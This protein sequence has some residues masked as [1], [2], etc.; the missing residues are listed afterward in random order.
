MGIGDIIYTVLI[1]PIELLFEVIY[2]IAETRIIHDY[3]LSIVV[4]S[5]VVNILVL[6]L[7]MRADVVQ[8]RERQ[9]EKEMEKGIKHIKKTFSGNERQMM[10]QAYYR[11]C[12]YNPLGMF[13]Q[14][15]SLAIQI[16]FFIA[17]YHFL[18]NLAQLQ[19]WSFWFITDLGKPD[20][21]LRVGTFAINIL[22]IVM[23]LIN[24][25]NCAIFTKGYTLKQKL[26]LYGMAIFFLVFL[27]NS[28]AGLV[29]YWTLNNLFSLL[30][31]LFYRLKNAKA[32]M[33]YIMAGIGALGVLF[34]GYLL[35]QRTFSMAL[36]LMVAMASC[37]L[38]IPL[39]K[40]AGVFRRV[41]RNISVSEGDATIS[42]RGLFWLCMCFLTVFVGVLI[43]SAVMAESPQEFVDLFQFQHPLWL[44]LSSMCYAVGFFLVWIPVFYSIAT[45]QIKRVIAILSVIA[46]IMVIADYMVFGKN[47]GILD[48]TLTYEKDMIYSKLSVIINLMLL[49]IVVILIALFIKRM[50]T[51]LL[52]GV[53]IVLGATIVMSVLNVNTIS[54]GVT[55]AVAG[56]DNSEKDENAPSFT[57]SQKGKNVIVV[58]MDRGV[59]HL[60]PYLFNEKPELYE[61]F[62]GFTYYPNTLSFGSY[63][64]V[65]SPAL[66]G[67]YEYTPYEMNIRDTELLVDKH[68]EAL[69]V[70][71]VLF[72]ENGFDV[73][74]CDPTFAG[75]QWIPDLSIY[76]EYPNI[77]T[78]VTNG[79]FMQ[80]GYVAEQFNLKKRNFFCFAVTKSAPLCLQTTL[81]YGGSY[82]HYSG[83]QL[84]T[85]ANKATGTTNAFVKAFTALQHFSDMTQISEGNQNTFLMI[86]NDSTHEA[87]FLQEPEYDL[88][89]EVDNTE[90]EAANAERYTLNGRTLNMD[91]VYARQT[92]Q[93]NM[94]SLI[95]L[96][97]WLDSLRE[98]D[99]YDNSRII[100]VS[101]HGTGITF[102]DDIEAGV[103]R[104][105]NP[106]LMVKDFGAQEFTVSDE[107]MTNA[108]VP[109]LTTDGLIENPVNPFTG[110]DISD[111]IKLIAPL[112]IEWTP[113]TN[114]NESIYSSC[115]YCPGDWF[116][117]DGDVRDLDSFKAL[118]EN[119]VMPYN[120]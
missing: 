28:P 37:A 48:T 105:F 21:L 38:C 94:A 114:I 34:A 63:T 104:T 116:E 97:K 112:I 85:G 119:S 103:K 83:K 8:E 75:Y 79:Y 88:A 22:P 19:D 101:D 89:V 13:K 110:K 17:A 98:N 23:T 35:L 109:V 52:R 46:S 43:P 111:T 51:W 62:A 96:G 64:M 55:R 57:L 32:I 61:K 72:D 25:L 66:Y 42:Y 91:S 67:G 86:A 47:F 74:V 24:L 73:T 53:V 39:L 60:I 6:P 59:G 77:R 78:F 107:F 108:D 40:K 11:A 44:L 5:I 100:I 84:I 49:A 81:Y 87:T 56:V 92:Y 31:T 113:L 3:G 54:R 58:M 41:S 15:L 26:Q 76:D 70:M 68:N 1:A 99:V 117:V 50:R 106:W 95:Q 30:K 65:G 115:V 80:G 36:C 12:R 2:F 27:Y 120:E 10:L 9:L 45:D 71:P 4:L 7:Y 118:N 14:L 33:V 90:Y 82:N 102:A 16:P 69:K 93:I 20:A 18:S 29:F